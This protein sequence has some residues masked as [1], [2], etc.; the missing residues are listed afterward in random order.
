MHCGEPAKCVTWVNGTAGSHRESPLAQHCNMQD[1]K[2]K[3]FLLNSAEFCSAEPWWWIL[4][5]NL[6]SLSDIVTAVINDIK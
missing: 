1:Q 5:A 3:G 2:L 6:L 4:P